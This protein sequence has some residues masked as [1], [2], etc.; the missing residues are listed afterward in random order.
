MQQGKNDVFELGQWLRTRYNTFLGDL[1]SPDK[2]YAQSTGVS[3]TKMSL[4][5]VLAG[6]WPPK[7]TPLEW[8]NQLNWQPVPF[9]YE[10]LD[11][12]TVNAINHIFVF[13]FFEK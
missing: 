13:F 4:A 10:P 3:R 9:E 8:N 6:L 11:K 12:D 5:L 2:V 7:N 1:Y